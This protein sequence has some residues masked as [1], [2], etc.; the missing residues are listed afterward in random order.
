VSEELPAEQVAA[1]LNRHLAEMT[2]IV[3]NHGG[4]VDKFIGDAIMAFWGA[5]V[6]DPKQCEHALAAAIDMQAKIAEMRR[7]FAATGGPVL[8]MRIGLHRGECIVG[9]LGGSL[10]FE[11]TAIGDTVNLASRLEGVNNVYGTGILL[12]GE[13]ARAIAG[14]ARLRP[15][16]SVRVK[17]KQQA[18]ELYT[19]CED[20]TLVERTLPAL[21]A[22]RHG[23]WPQAQALWQALAR[24]YPE[25]PVVAV[26]VGRLAAWAAQG[27]P[28]PW[29]GV[30]TLGS[31]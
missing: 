11:Y 7:E 2:E 13:V 15:V 5:P 24:D 6:A 8:R 10:R 28:Q 20:A 16:D 31:K 1:I 27:W 29:D 30:W 25:D 4:T 14:M 9:N 18:V 26:F 17:G 12:S 19:P 21:D 22:W 23:D 3:I